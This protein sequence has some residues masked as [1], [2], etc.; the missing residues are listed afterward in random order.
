MKY[1][2]KKIVE[3][4]SLKG[5]ISFCVMSFHLEAFLGMSEWVCVCVCMYVFREWGTD[6]L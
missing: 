2:E 5:E 4:I 1:G 6:T 3:E